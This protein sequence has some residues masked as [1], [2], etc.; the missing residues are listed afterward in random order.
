MAFLLMILTLILVGCK[1]TSFDV[2]PLPLADD[3][4]DFEFV[5]NKDS[6][7]DPIDYE[8]SQEIRISDG[9]ML[10]V[11]DFFRQKTTKTLVSNVLDTKI[12]G[13][14]TGSPRE[15]ARQIAV[16]YNLEYAEFGNVLY[17]VSTSESPALN[18][19]AAFRCDL[20]KEDLQEL[21]QELKFLRRDNM[22]VVYGPFIQ[23]K[24]FAEF[25][26]SLNSVNE[27]NYLV[28][29][30]EVETSLDFALTL[31]ME[32]ASKGVDIV[33][34]GLTAYDVFSAVARVNGQSINSDNYHERQLVLTSGQATTYSRS[35]DK[36]LEMRAISDQGTSTVSGYET[37][38]AGVILNMEVNSNNEDFVQLKYDIEMSNFVGATTDKT[39]V[40]ANSDKVLVKP[41]AIYY[42]AS[43]EDRRQEKSLLLAGFGAAKDIVVSSIFVKIDK[44]SK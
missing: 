39:I 17:L 36:K 4:Y 19:S 16:A 30:V 32:I 23:V 5:E 9:T 34:P 7:F 40:R 15:I 21:F 1:S 25:V 41:G 13:L 37:L 11:A 28:T 14:F 29:V 43:S 22:T 12:S 24:R 6:Q 31:Q 20:S 38:S 8:V 35:T 33:R 44:I 27:Q 2:D 42:L 26:E 3:R 18:I 10:D